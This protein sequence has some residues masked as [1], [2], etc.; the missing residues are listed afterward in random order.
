LRGAERDSPPAAQSESST[1]LEDSSH[2]TLSARRPCIAAHVP[3]ATTATPSGT[4]TTSVT[5]CTFFASVASKDTSLAPKLG[6]HA[7]T[8]VSNPGSFTSAVYVAVP[9][10]LEGESTRGVERSL[11][12]NAVLRRAFSV[13]IGGGACLLAAACHL[14]VRRATP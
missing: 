2:C 3:V 5:P 14:A 7:I 9:L 4:S 11:P 8:A 1:L 10:H 13:R 12:M 6:G